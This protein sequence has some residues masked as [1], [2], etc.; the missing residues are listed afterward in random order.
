VEEEGKRK[1]SQ[2]MR[3]LVKHE[4]KMLCLLYYVYVQENKIYINFDPYGT[5]E[6]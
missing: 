2:S 6:A 4:I 5:I 3:V 1:R